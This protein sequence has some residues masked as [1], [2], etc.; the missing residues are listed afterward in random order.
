MMIRV[1]F[2]SDL[3]KVRKAIKKVGIEMQEDPVLG[4]QFL[5]PLK[6]QGAVDTDSSGFVTSVKFVSRPGEQ[7]V[8][9]REAFARIQKAFAENG[10]EFAAPRI[11]VD[12]EDEG[13]RQAAAGAMARKMEAEAG[14]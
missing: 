14:H 4:P 10:I 8:L 3:N 1:P 6:S 11:T 9:R 12:S 13:E 5:E 7:F 2:D